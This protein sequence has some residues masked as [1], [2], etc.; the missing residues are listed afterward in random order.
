MCVQ[1]KKLVVS[2]FKAEEQ[3]AQTGEAA[4]V[5]ACAD[6]QDCHEDVLSDVPSDGAGGS[7]GGA[8]RSK[9]TSVRKENGCSV[10]TCGATLCDIRKAEGVV[11][12]PAALPVQGAFCS[13]E[14][15]GEG[16]GVAI[17]FRLSKQP[18]MWRCRKLFRIVA[19]F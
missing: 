19:N 17:R 2:F 5:E 15:A 10:H 14:C 12:V 11:Y 13:T 8:R 18:T 9:R 6:A 1:A 3:A 16:G 7:A 4:A